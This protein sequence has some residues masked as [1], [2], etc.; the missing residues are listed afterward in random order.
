MKKQNDFKFNL[1][2]FNNINFIKTVREDELP[3]YAEA[4]RN[5]II[6]AVSKNGGHLSSNL[7]SVELI[8]AL[9]RHYDIQK[10]KLLFDVGHQ[11]Y[12]HKL[13]TEE[14]YLILEQKIMYP[15]F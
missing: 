8:M 10:D 6:K 7:G 11:A 2:S 12:V 13:L 3:L 4:F 9:H 15:A 14:I 5:E 1:N